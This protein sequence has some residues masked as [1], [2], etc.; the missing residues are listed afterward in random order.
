MKYLYILLIQNRTSF[1]CQFRMFTGMK[2]N[3]YGNIE[4]LLVHVKVVTPKGVL[5]KNCQVPRMSCGPDF[6]H[7]ILGS[8]GTLGIITEVIIKI[9]PL[10]QCKKYGSVIFPTYENGLG[11]MREIA[12]QRCQPA[13]VRL[14]DNEQFRFGHSLKPEVSGLRALT[15]GIKK[16][17]VTKVKG[18]DVYKMC[19]MTLLFEGREDEVKVQEKR[20]Y[21]IAANHGGLPAG[22][23]NGERGYLFTFVIAYIRVSVLVI[24]N[25]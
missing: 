19:V 18:F 22:E 25:I 1:Y 21:G 8:E 10:P 17:Y 13:S 6:N 14:M 2:K 3:V 7:L 24:V 20:L 4:D 11:C 9:R 23:E 12:L 15:E 5:Q 16:V